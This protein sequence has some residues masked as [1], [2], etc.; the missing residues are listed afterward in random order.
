MAV[1]EDVLAALRAVAAEH[2]DGEDSS[3]VDTEAGEDATEVGADTFRRTTP[4]QAEMLLAKVQDQAEKEFER[5]WKAERLEASRSN[6]VKA[7]A[8]LANQNR[9][10]LR[11]LEAKTAELEAELQLK[12]ATDAQLKKLGQA[13]VA[14][15]RAKMT[16]KELAPPDPHDWRQAATL[17]FANKKL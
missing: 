15:Q 9:N 4:R 5:K 12:E 10:L 11:S 2:D 17:E 7:A 13:H 8:I 6:P 3:V 1:L 14:L 16:A